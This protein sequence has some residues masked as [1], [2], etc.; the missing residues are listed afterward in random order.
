MPPKKNEGS[1]KKKEAAPKP[2]SKTK[3][4]V[5]VTLD[6][7][8]K[9][10]K[11]GNAEYLISNISSAKEGVITK[12]AV[13]KML[14][15]PGGVK[16]LLENFSK[17]KDVSPIS[18]AEMIIE[19]GKGTVA[20]FNNE[21][22]LAKSRNE[23]SS[24]QKILEDKIGHY[25]KL[26]TDPDTYKR[27]LQNDEVFQNN[28]LLEVKLLSKINKQEKFVMDL[29]KNQL[30]TKC[31]KEKNFFTPERLAFFTKSE[32]GNRVIRNLEEALIMIV[33]SK[34]YDTA[35][36]N[37][38]LSNATDAVDGKGLSESLFNS[39]K[40]NGFKDTTVSYAKKF[41]LKED[42][43]NEDEVETVY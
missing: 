15:A 29:D 30:F 3:E 20:L 25:K 40:K 33:E 12:D 42:S 38:L 7:Y 17:L 10:V 34:K 39:L 1:A 11:E 5:V 2:I 4:K 24:A 37:A 32:G 31:L 36:I 28:S 41:N 23:L 22:D 26:N 13:S 18:L 14:K 6:D 35:H 9:A 16:A 19:S 43:K 21:L 8:E 27:N